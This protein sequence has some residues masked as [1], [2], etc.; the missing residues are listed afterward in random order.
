VKRVLITGASG[1]V[2]RHCIPHLQEHGYEVHA[3]SRTRSISTNVVWHRV[4]LL[5]ARATTALIR[6]VEP[7]A[8]LHLAWYAQPGAFWEA[9]ENFEWLTASIQL[10][11]EFADA[12][13]ERLIGVGTCAEYDWS[14]GHCEERRTPCVPATLYGACKHSLYLLSEAIARRENISTAWARM[15]FLYGPYEHSDRF[16]P[17]VIRALLQDE[18]APTTSGEQERDFMH[19]DDVASALVSLMDSAVEGP[20]NIASGSPVRLRDIALNI[21]RTLNRERLLA[22][23]A[24]PSRA[25]EPPLLTASTERLNYEVRWHPRRSLG[26]GLADTIRWWQS[27]LVIR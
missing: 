25:N 12:G 2:G 27:Q 18:P 8:L 22:I 14:G 9:N 10:F 24:L 17:S 4:D 5:D 21:G 20:V 7:H 13:G 26:T 15:F 1:F 11:R 6:K 16:I 19:V 3:V 23:G